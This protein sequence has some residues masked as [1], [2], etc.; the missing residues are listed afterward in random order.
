MTY[1]NATFVACLTVALCGLSQ[2]AVGAS[3]CVS[4][5]PYPGC[6]YST[7]GA[8]VAAASA[9]DVV[10]VSPG[11]YRE[12]VVIGKAISLVGT[13]RFTTTIDA[14]GQPNG[15]YVDGL[16]NPGLFG[17]SVSGDRK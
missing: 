7:I 16:D 17:V 11:P 1:R 2:I 10:Q 9:G 5:T 4:K 8:A 6:P 12:G 13:S 15:I 14:S 3:L